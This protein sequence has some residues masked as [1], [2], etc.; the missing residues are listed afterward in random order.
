MN[1]DAQCSCKL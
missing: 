1:A